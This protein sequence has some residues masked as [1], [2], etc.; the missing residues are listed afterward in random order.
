MVFINMKNRYV[1]P[2]EQ[3]ARLVLQY[4][5]DPKSVSSDRVGLMEKSIVHWSNKIDIT[6]EE[7]YRLQMIAKILKQNK[8]GELEERKEL[9]KEHDINW[10]KFHRLPEM[11]DLGNDISI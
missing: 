8:D 9:F 11:E 4:V 3:L 2:L 10:A 5:Y 1:L 7:L 6:E